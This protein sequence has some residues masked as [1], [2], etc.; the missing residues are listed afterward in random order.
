VD[1]ATCAGHLQ[2]PSLRREVGLKAAG[3]A[4]DWR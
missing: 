4:V 1:G 2:K 3:A